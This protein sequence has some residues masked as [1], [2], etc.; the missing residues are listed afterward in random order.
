MLR[1]W[2]VGTHVSRQYGGLIKVKIFFM[3]HF[4]P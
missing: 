2:I 1:H 4:D 3:G